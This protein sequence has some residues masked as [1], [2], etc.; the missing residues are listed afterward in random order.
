MNWSCSI[1]GLG[2]VHDYLRA[3]GKDDFEEVD[4]N[5]WRVYNWVKADSEKI[6][7]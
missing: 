6:V 2:K 5:I 7:V 1:D 4:A 3:G